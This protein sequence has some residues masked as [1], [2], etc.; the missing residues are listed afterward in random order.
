VKKPEREPD[1]EFLREKV[2]SALNTAREG[3]AQISVI[4]RAMKEFAYADQGEKSIADIDHALAA[5]LTV[6]R[7]EYKYVA[8]VE[9]DYGHLTQVPCR[10]G[11]MNQV[12]LNLIVNAA[13]AI[14][15]RVKGT[16]NKGAIRVRT[17]I[18]GPNARIDISD[19]GVG[20]P[21][22]I[23]ERVFEPFF[24]TKEVG[25]GSGQG[26]AL[27]RSIVEGKHGGTL[28]FT[29]EVG[30]GTTF[31]IRIPRATS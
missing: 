9:T 5:T 11:E 12:F 21:E 3:I 19:T 16:S 14:S 8:E 26:L 7:T 1:I 29:S 23:R 13:H 15:D 20:I 10:I 22:S 28:T 18:E 6:A 2:P 4:V 24:T 25:R 27:A 31:T 17:S 30:Q